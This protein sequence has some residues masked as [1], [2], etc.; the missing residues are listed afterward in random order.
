[1]RARRA[2]SF[3]RPSLRARVHAIRAQ[4]AT[5]LREGSSARA[6]YQHLKEQHRET[7][8]ELARA[9]RHAAARSAAGGRARSPAAE[10]LPYSSRAGRLSRG[11]ATAAAELEAELERARRQVDEQLRVR[12]RAD[13]GGAQSQSG[14][15][16]IRAAA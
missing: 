4:V 13:G 10:A 1:M 7:R 16:A 11:E 5:A 8:K 6:E 15:S 2:R 12:H 9:Q 14:I 3:V